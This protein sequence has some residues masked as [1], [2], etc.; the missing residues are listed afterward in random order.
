VIKYRNTRL[1]F[2][3][4]SLQ[5]SQRNLLVAKDNGFTLIELMVAIAVLAM[6]MA[7]VFTL[8][9][10]TITAWENGNR[11]LEAS[12]AARV[13]L[14]IVAVELENALSGLKV[15]DVLPSTDRQTNIFPIAA[16]KSANS[17]PGLSSTAS[18]KV[19]AVP[20]SDQV[21]FI[22]PT[23]Y[24]YINPSGLPYHESGFIS[25]FVNTRRD[26]RGL[27]HNN[28]GPGYYL[29]KHRKGPEDFY[30]RG[31]TNAV[32]TNWFSDNSD[33]SDT[34][35]PIIDNCLRFKLTPMQTNAAGILSPLNNWRSF[36]TLPPEVV[37]FL[38]EI[39]TIDSRTAAKLAQL[40]PDTVLT[41]SD[42]DSIT[43][44]ATPNSDIQRLIR[45]GSVIMGRYIPL[46]NKN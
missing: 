9:A 32:N 43:N 17:V 37:G 27:G 46:R 28:M 11:R 40:R 8:L 13:G 1:F 6:M 24:S 3:I 21:F 12:I 30:F 2:E 25:L 38:A 5:F 20:G 29:V 42:I 41:E 22:F 44:S 34:R 35:I 7:F 14:N 10:S 23:G 36:N 18:R 16:I 15:I 19:V 4:H 33:S 45:S 26:G 39:I 31:A